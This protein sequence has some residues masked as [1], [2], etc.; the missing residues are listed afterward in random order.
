[1]PILLKTQ[2]E[3]AAKM[4]VTACRARV[5][6][7]CGF[8]DTA[9]RVPARSPKTGRCANVRRKNSTEAQRSGF[10][11]KRRC[12][13]MDETCRLRRG[14]GYGACIDE[15][16]RPDKITASKP[17]HTSFPTTMSPRL[18]HALRMSQPSSPHCSKKIG[19]G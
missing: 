15:A 3:S 18:S 13:E 1:M 12:S 2:V 5:G 14:E 9:E 17:I 10:G 19:N 7:L 11:R 8:P 6:G 16:A 4:P